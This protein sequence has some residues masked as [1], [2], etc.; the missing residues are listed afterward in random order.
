MNSFNNELFGTNHMPGTMLF[1]VDT[2]MGKIKW[3]CSQE[4]SMIEKGLFSVLNSQFNS[5]GI[6][7]LEGR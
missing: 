7:T 6:C 1:H 3:A 4:L 5:Q 2:L